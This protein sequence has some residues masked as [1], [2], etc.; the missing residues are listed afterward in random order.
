MPEFIQYDSD[1]IDTPAVV[2]HVW[3]AMGRTVA[4]VA[5]SACPRAE[6][7]VAADFP[8]PVHLAVARALEICEICGLDK[9]AVVLA[10]GLEWRQDW[11][12]LSSKMQNA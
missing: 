7:Y 3:Q 12:P 5:C 11:A 2:L 1:Q 9:V 10:E 4:D 6:D 8:R